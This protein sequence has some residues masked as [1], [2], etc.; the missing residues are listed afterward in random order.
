MAAWRVGTQRSESRHRD[1]SPG[2][3]E[4]AAVFNTSITFAKL[5]ARL[6]Y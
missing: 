3:L 4:E 6:V 2:V 1:R 5:D